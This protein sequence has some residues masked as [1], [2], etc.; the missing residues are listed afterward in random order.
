KAVEQGFYVDIGACHPVYDSVTHHFYLKGWKGV[1]VEPQPELFSELQAK[2]P[3]DSN[4]NVCIGAEPGKQSLYVTSD[5]GTSTIDP[6]L[7]KRY[8]SLGKV[9]DEI[10][11]SVITLND[12]WR[13]TVGAG[14]VNFLKIDVEGL[15]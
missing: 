11:V 15:E 6:A 10:E 9:V 3:R 8:R 13:E 2:R 4:F 7:G 12:L 14:K 1:N 5:V